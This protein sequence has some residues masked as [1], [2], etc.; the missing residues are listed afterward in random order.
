MKLEDLIPEK[1]TFYLSSMQKTYQLRLPNLEDRVNMAKHGDISKIFAERRWD[2]I[3]KVIYPLLIDKSDFMASKEHKIDVEGFEQEVVVI[4]P[5]RLLRAISTQEEAIGL[6]GAFNSAITASE[7][8]IKDFVQG[9]LKKKIE[10]SPI[11]ENSSI[12][13][14]PSMDTLSTSSA[15]SRSGSLA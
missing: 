2:D 3:C 7:P 4:G 8:L 13:L 14:H 9:E 11:G 6:I 1:P 12:S 15:G 5:I 10:L